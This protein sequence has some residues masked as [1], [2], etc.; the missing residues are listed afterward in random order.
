MTLFFTLFPLYI[1]GNIHCLGMCGPLVMMLGQHRY[2]LLYFAGRLLSFS[3]AGLLA[4][5]M[6]AVLQL[7]LK[8]YHFSAVVSLAGGV[9][10]IYWGLSLLF[11]WKFIKG[12][13]QWKILAGINR[14]LSMLLLKETAWSTFFFGFA[15]VLLP[16]GQ[17]LVVFSACAL[18][19][20]PLVGLFN[21][22]AFALLTSPS[23]VLAMHAFT[24][25]KGLKKYSNPILGMC[26]IFV[27]LLSCCRGIA[28]MGWM[29]HWILNPDSQPL[30]HIAI[31]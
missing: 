10:I 3:L 25:F 22:F 26:S 11:N 18:V 19:G 9:L 27:G 24:F 1:F 21:G 6:G 28:D 23:L 30:Y 2:R 5:E 17:T 12:L 16:C 15:T 13:G 7:F 20:D 31:F 4:G 29:S 14:M 8:P